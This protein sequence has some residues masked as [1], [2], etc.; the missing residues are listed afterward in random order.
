MR[1]LIRPFL[2]R[3]RLTALALGALLVFGLAGDL[4][5]PA[6]PAVALLALLAALGLAA[7]LVLA[8]L[9][10]EAGW[11]HG[12]LT[13]AA[14]LLVGFGALAAAQ[15]LVG[16]PR[17]L[18]GHTS[19]DIAELQDGLLGTPPRVAA[20]PE[21]LRAALDQPDAP[22]RQR[23]ASAD[24]FLY[25]AILLRGRDQPVAAAQALAEVLRRAAEPRPDA[26]V[27]HDGLIA[28]GLP[29]V[30]EALATLPPGSAPE[31]R[32]HLEAMRLPEGRERAAALARIV[33]A[34]DTALVAAAALVRSLIAGSL[35]QGPTIATA[36]RIAGLVA[37]FEDE[38]RLP[39]FAARFLH[40][41]AA[42]RLQEEMLALGWT[43]DVAARRISIA[44]Q[45]PPLGQPNAPILL[46][47]TTPEPASSVQFLRGADADGPLWAEVAQRQG[48]P[49]PTL[50][51]PRPWR[52]QEMQFRYLDRDGVISAPLAYAFDP[53]TAIREQ[54]QRTLQRQ[55]P[56]ALYQPGRI[57][58][59]RLNNFPIVGHLRAG[60]IAVEWATDVERRPRVVP[61]GVPDEVLLAGDP[62]RIVVEF[63][64]PT[65]ARLLILTAVYADGSRSPTQELAIR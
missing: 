2:D 65:N 48:E 24:E 30:M 60:L 21:R 63:Q 41:A 6:F 32:A 34:D 56:F 35:P 25:N 27:L 19:R 61:V 55:G 58:G 40:P 53:A 54:A 39:G 57:A 26:L 12:V 52:V 59:G 64:V 16:A 10:P 46:R 42:A 1:R 36:S 11:P 20:E 7:G 45:A 49:A 14:M 22:L 5:E 13:L 23:P 38:D 29:G 4:L 31:T 18:L 43:R 17:G 8:R 44:A 9:R 62:P 50:R 15:L 28:T 33:E 3:P 47:I 37:A 51:V